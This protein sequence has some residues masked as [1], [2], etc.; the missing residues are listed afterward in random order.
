MILAVFIVALGLFLQKPSPVK[1]QTPLFYL[2]LSSYYP[3]SINYTPPTTT[4]PSLQNSTPEKLPPLSSS[5]PFYTIALLGDSMID[6]LGRNI[7]NLQKA[8]HHYYPNFRF[9]ILNY[10]YGASNIEY[11]LFRLT[12]NYSYLN[13]NFPSL[14]SLK[15]DIIVVESFAYN[16]FGNNQEGFDRQRQ[17]LE[18]ITSEIQNSSPQTKILLAS[19]I[20]PNSVFF[21]NGIPGIDYNSFEKIEKT[22][23]IKL[24]LQNLINFAKTNDFPLA[25]AYHPSLTANDGDRSLINPSDN[26]HPSQRGSDFFCS[27]LAKSIF[28][29]QLIPQ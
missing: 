23:T 26:L 22:E 29:N 21:A 10:G 15:P 19:T 6:T 27:I 8:L 7:P 4:N 11:A 2:L 12:H 13:Q 18:K 17:A 28:E 3:T 24:Y 25:N 16:N 1:A 20:A 5:A 14:I 9:Q